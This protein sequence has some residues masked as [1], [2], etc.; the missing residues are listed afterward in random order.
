MT[1]VIDN[2]VIDN[3]MID[4]DALAD[5]LSSLGLDD[6]SAA[7]DPILQ[8]RFSKR[9]HGDFERWQRIV[10]AVADAA[11][12][13]EKLRELLLGLSPWRKGPFR[14][15][16]IDIDAEWRSDIKWARVAGAIEPLSGR[17]VLD[18]GCGN[19][20]YALEMQKAGA[21]AVIGI[22]PTLLYV[23]QFL[24]VNIFERQNRVF[25]L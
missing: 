12:D 15:A 6:W 16:D 21:D 9:T 1:G 18:V 13:A 20:Y 23:M 8:A 5:C 2:G 3:G 24:A 11:G 25:V 17:R 4:T 7:L 14:I 19:G 22:D 10:G